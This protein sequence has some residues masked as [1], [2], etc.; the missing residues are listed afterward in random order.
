MYFPVLDMHVSVNDASVYNVQY[1][2]FDYVWVF[3]CH[4]STVL[5]I[6][7]FAFSHIFYAPCLFAAA[8]S[9]KNLKKRVF[10]P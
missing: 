4:S 9:Q 10:L 2:T 6:K 7:N 3:C 8:L 5:G 1:V